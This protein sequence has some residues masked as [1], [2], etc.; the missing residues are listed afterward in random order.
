[1]FPC[2]C[3]GYLVHDEPAGS[4]AICPICYWEDD[5]VQLRWPAYRGGANKAS[6]VDAQQNYADSGASELQFKDLVRAPQE[7]ERRDEGW[8]VIGHMTE[9]FEPTGDTTEP[10]PDDRA[11]L[12]WWRPTF[13]RRK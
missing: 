11:T 9:L 3:C 13:W 8:H 2:P 5:L 1:M 12:Y 6:L 10:W 7:N 4:H